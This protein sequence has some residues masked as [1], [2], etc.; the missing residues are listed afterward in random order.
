MPKVSF[1]Q[2]LKAGKALLGS[3]ILGAV[4]NRI[5]GTI[6]G[7]R[8]RRFKLTR[9]NSTLHRIKTRSRR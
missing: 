3:K 6:A 9:G 4:N 8:I 1:R 2:I 5:V 7:G